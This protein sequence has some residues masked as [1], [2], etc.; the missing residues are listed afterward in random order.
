MIHRFNGHARL[1]CDE[2]FRSDEFATKEAAQTWA[3][4]RGWETIEKGGG[5]ILPFE[6][7]VC[8]LCKARKLWARAA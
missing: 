8:D 7:H 2:C 6:D 5:E 3:D 4:Q 1:R